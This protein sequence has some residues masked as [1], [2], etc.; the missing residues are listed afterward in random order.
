M[1]IKAVAVHFEPVSYM[2]GWERPGPQKANLESSAMPLIHGICHYSCINCCCR[3]HDLHVQFEQ[4][5]QEKM[6]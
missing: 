5:G 6:S 2:D 3:W 4:K 1:P